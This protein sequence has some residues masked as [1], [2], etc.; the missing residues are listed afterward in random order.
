MHVEREKRQ[1]KVLF[2]IESLGCGGAEKSLVSLLSLL[3]RRKYDLSIWMIH[4]EGA[5]KYLLPND[6]TVVEQ[7]R[8]NTF[9]SMLLNLSAIM[10]SCVLRLNKIFARSEY[11]GETYYKSRGWA[12][13]APEGQWDIVFAY[14]PYAEAIFSPREFWPSL[15][16]FV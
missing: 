11:W 2:V 14:L 3:D 5:F 13:K 12:I 1:T 8:Y 6:I 4:P 10:Y 7:P 15:L 9:D 16:V